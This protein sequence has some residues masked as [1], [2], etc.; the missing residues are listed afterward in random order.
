MTLATTQVRAKSQN[1]DGSTRKVTI[2]TMKK[3]EG[4][5][6]DLVSDLLRS[7]TMIETSARTTEART[8]NLSR[9]DHEYS[10]LTG[11]ATSTKKVSM[12]LSS[13]NL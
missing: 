11:T 1:A 3:D 5:G 12:C 9:V 7:I 10:G 13:K 4:E 6:L 8:I 2:L